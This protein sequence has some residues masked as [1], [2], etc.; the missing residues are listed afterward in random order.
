MVEGDEFEGTPSGISPFAE[1]VVG[2]ARL[3]PRVFGSE[4]W[5]RYGSDG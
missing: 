4:L 3:G 2:E 5:D 1:A